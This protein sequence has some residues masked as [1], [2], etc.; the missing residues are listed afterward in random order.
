MR[1][2]FARIDM[3]QVPRLITYTALP[4]TD[5]R[6]SMTLIT[7]NCRTGFLGTRFIHDADKFSRTGVSS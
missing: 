2:G 7:G 3:A 4:R 6:F 1:S 5:H